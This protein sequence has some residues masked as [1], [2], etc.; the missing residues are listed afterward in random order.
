M[1]SRIYTVF[2]HNPFKTR[3]IT[4]LPF[5]LFGTYYFMTHS[6]YGFTQDQRY[7]VVKIENAHK[8]ADNIE[9]DGCIVTFK[10]DKGEKSRWFAHIACKRFAITKQDVLDHLDARQKQQEQTIQHAKEDLEPMFERIDRLISSINKAE[11]KL[12]KI[13]ELKNKFSGK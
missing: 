10:D 3:S 5:R 7:R 12:K 11:D 2:R 1:S 6:E 4:K 13:E 9:K 8:F